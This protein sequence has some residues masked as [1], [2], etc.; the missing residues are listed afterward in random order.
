LPTDDG[1]PSIELVHR[2]RGGSLVVSWRG[3]VV[4]LSIEMMGSGEFVLRFPPNV[5]RPQRDA[6]R[7]EIRRWLDARGRPGWALEN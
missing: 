4:E 5:R 7:P 6:L 3:K 2:G 1:V